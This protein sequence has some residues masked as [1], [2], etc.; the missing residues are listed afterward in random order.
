MTKDSSTAGPACSAA[1]VPAMTKMPAP[2]I[3]P[4]PSM[5][6][7]A[8]PRERCSS[9]SLAATGSGCTRSP[10][11]SPLTRSFRRLLHLN[12]FGRFTV[13]PAVGHEDNDPDYAPHDQSQPRI[14]GQ[15]C[16]HEQAH[17]HAER[18]DEPDKRGTEWPRCIGRLHAQH[19]DSDADNREG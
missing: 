13:T 11:A 2:M 10:G 3:S 19:Q 16:H 17:A 12:P 1:A 18:C 7:L 15:E 9:C 6:R 5:M 14:E 4:M 8:G